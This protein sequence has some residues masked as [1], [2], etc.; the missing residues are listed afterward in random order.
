MVSTNK[1]SHGGFCTHYELMWKYFKDKNGN[2][3]G[4]AGCCECCLKRNT[5][6]HICSAAAQLKIKFNGSNLVIK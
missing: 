6:T 2:L 3:I 1:C 4:C 5:C